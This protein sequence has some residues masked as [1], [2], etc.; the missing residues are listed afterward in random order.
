[1]AM[2]YHKVITFTEDQVDMVRDKCLFLVGESDP[3]MTLGGK[4]MLNRYN[5][6]VK[7]FTKVGHGINHEIADPGV[8][9]NHA[10]KI[11]KRIHDTLIE[12]F[13]DKIPEGVSF[14]AAF[15]LS[16]R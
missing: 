15:C 1:M 4:E 2:R 16:K 10:A 9:V 14:S 8:K 3:F 13:K 12:E 11:M 6:H 7:Y 5:M